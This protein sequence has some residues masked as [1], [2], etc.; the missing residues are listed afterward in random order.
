MKLNFLQVY[1]SFGE[2]Y[3][4]HL[5]EKLRRKSLWKRAYE[6]NLKLKYFN[7]VKVS[8]KF[9]KNVSMRSGDLEVE[10]L[11]FCI[12]LELTK[13]RKVKDLVKNWMISEFY[14][15]SETLIQQL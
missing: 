6:E 1:W 13:A 14:Q 5:L 10:G 11:D 3:L 8:G 15:G 12:E 7:E 4:V 2:R 9:F